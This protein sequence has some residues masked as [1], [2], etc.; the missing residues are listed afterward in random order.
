MLA[1]IAGQ[2]LLGWI[3]ADFFGGLLHWVEDRQLLPGFLDRQ[4]GAP[5]RLHHSD[6]QG[7]TRDA[8]FLRRN[9]TTFAAAL[10]I[11]VV[12]YFLFGANAFWAS[13]S[14]GG[15]LSY[16]VHR[17]AH[18]PRLAPG[19]ARVLQETGFLQ[20]PKHH[21]V[22]HR[23]PQDRHFCILTNWLNPLLDA[24]RFWERLERAIGL[25]GHRS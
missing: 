20:S 21:A 9:S 19:W 2:L 22:H 13:S 3:Y 1:S 18:A 7:V 11:V 4:I 24:L 17:W 6:P 5:N 25:Q 10:P 12:S 14:I 8:N 15:L 23:P 16:E